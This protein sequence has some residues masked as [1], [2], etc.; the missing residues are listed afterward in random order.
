MRIAFEE[1]KQEFKRVLHSLGFA[2]E[3]AECC[4]S[5][6]ASNSRDG[7]YSHGLNRFPVFVR[8]VKEGL[9]NIEAEPAKIEGS[10]VIEHWDGKQGAGPYNA[11]LAMKR[12]IEL[13]K[14]KGLGLVSLKNTNHWMRGGS[15]GWQASDAGCIGICTTNTIANMP[16]W[17]GKEPRLG[18]NPL[19]I[20]VPRKE[21]AVVLD[22]AVSQYSYGALQQYQLD[23]KK[24]PVPGGYDQA[25]NL[26]QD[27]AAIYQSQRV[28]PVGFWKGSGLSMV[29]DILLVALSGGDSV[30]KISSR[31]NET[32]ITQLFIAIF[33]EELHEN[34]INEIIDFTKSSAPAEQGGRIGYPGEQTL[35]TRKENLAQGIPVNEK[36]WT[37]VLSL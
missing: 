31:Q 27:P 12:A 20:A 24:L 19:V 5:L 11:H 37:E 4:A 18:N 7:V 17:G 26:T 15:Y 1:M 36:I 35:A 21:G 14:E 34:L 30:K 9:I 32:G 29:L 25:G 16:P 28:L 2:G 3:K 23:G 6:F 13:A 33:Q 8:Y 10:T 22:M